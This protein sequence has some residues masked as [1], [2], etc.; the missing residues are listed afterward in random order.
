[1]RV[2]VHTNDSESATSTV[3]E[4]SVCWTTANAAPA[5]N[6]RAVLAWLRG[7]D[8]KVALRRAYAYGNGGEKIDVIA[9]DLAVSRAK[10]AKLLSTNYDDAITEVHLERVRTKRPDIWAALLNFRVES[11][12]AEEALPQAA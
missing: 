2:A 3:L 8:R 12:P 6:L 11:A 1:M 10:A 4:L 9:L 5:S 7:D